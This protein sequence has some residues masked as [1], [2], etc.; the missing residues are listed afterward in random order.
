M[1][2]MTLHHLRIGMDHYKAGA[3]GSAENHLRAVLRAQD[4][5]A[6]VHNMVGVTPSL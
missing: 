4:G 6:D 5:F 1:D 3:Y 2:A